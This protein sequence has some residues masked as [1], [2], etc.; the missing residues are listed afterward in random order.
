MK[1]RITVVF[2]LL[3][4][5]SLLTN[6][7]AAQESD[8][9]SANSEQF[10]QQISSIL[11]NTPSKTNQA[12]SQVILDRLYVRWTIGRFNKDEKDAVR[13][14]V[15][16]MRERKLKSYPYLYKYVYS[17]ML[18][19]ES[20]Q[21]PKSII[22]WHA[23]AEKMLGYKRAD[24]FVDFTDFTIELLEN[25]RLF[26][27][28]SLSWFHRQAR[29][30]F[31][32]DTNFLVK[33]E[34]LSLVCATKKDSSTIIETEGV[35][36]YDLQ[37]WTGKN[38][39][40]K[41]TRFGLENEDKIV[42]D[43]QDY[44]ID[45]SKSTYK[46]DSAVLHYERFFKNPVLGKFTEKIMSSPPSSR[47]SY[48]RFESYR[49]DFELMNIY[50]NINYYGGFYLNGLK[51]FG[52]GGEYNGAYITLNYNNEIFGKAN[53]EL[54]RLEEEKLEAQK[55]EVV[56]Y[57][58]KDSLYHPGLRLRYKTG[59]AEIQL[60]S[61][62]EGA[63]M[64]PFFD[65]YH[66]LDI[67][68]PAL[69]WKLDSTQMYFKRILGVHSEN[70]AAFVSSNYFSERDFYK[71][72]GI[73]EIN[74]MY[75]LQNYL[76][77][78]NDK[79]IQLNA[80]SAFMKKPTEQ[81]S[82][83]LINLSNNG[84]VV[85]NSREKTAIV[86]DR[87]YDFLDAK[88]GRSDYDIIRLESKVNR[89]ANAMLDLQ[90]LSLEVFGVP[91]VI[92][93]DSQD[94]YIYPYDNSISFKKNRDFSFDG[95]VHMGLFDF[96]S[97]SNTFVYDSFMINMN[98][99][100]SLAFKVYSTDSLSRIDSVIKVKNIVAE[101]N[102]KIYI[103]K[104]YNKSGLKKFEEYPIFI[105]EES[106]YVYFNEPF[107]QDSTLLADS[108]YFRIDPFQFDSIKT[109][110]T[111]GM[112]FSGTLVSAGIFPPIKQPLTVMPDYS[113]GFVHL[114]PDEGYPVYGGKGTFSDSIFLSNDGFSGSGKLD[115]LVSRT[116][117]DKYIFYP[118][119]LTSAAFEFKNMESPLEFDFPFAS[120]DTVNLKWLVDT[121][122]M[123]VENP[124]DSFSMY[125]NAKFDGNL[126]LNPENMNGLGAFHFEESEIQ[127]KYFTFNYSDLT[128]DSADFYLRKDVDTLVFQ[129]HGYFAKIDFEQQRAWFNHAYANTFV[130]FPYNKY[131][132]NLDEVEWLMDE[133][134]IE[135]FSDL[136]S[137]Y[138]GLDT[139]NDLDLIDYK[140]SGPEFI[141]IDNHPDSITRFFAGKATYNL[142]T[143][144]IDVENVK[145]IKS[146]DAAI[147]PNNEYVKILRDGGLL[148]L[149]NARIIADTLNKYHYIYEAEVDILNRHRYL[150]KGYI[151]YVD[152][153]LTRQPVYLLRIEIN[154]EGV[155]TG[156]G[157]MEPTEIFFLSPEYFFTG[158]I[159][160][161]ANN[162]FLNF[163]G[164]YRINEE[165][166][167]QEDKWVSFEKNLDP[168]NIYFNINENSLDLNQQKAR[169][170]LAYSA[171]LRS[172]YP[173]ILQSPVSSDDHVLIEAMGQIKYD[174]A[175]SSFRVSSGF[176][177]EKGVSDD[178]FVALNTTR[179]IL[180]GD[181]IFDLGLGFNKINITSAGKFRHLII[182]DSTYLNMAML[183]NFHFDD[184]AL[185]MMIDS[186]RLINS[187]VKNPGE[188]NFPVFLRK[189]LGSSKSTKLVTEISLYG[190][191]VK[192]PKAL[193]HTLIFSDLNM[194]W[195]GISNSFISQGP[196]GIGYIAGMPVNKYVNG[197]V[198]I[199]KGRSGSSINIY[200]E[201]TKN[202]W[203]FYTYQHGIMQVL[204]SDNEFNN[205]ISLLKPAKRVLNPESDT[206]YYEFVISTRRKV[207]DFLREMERIRKRF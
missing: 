13:S 184:G 188:G 173:L 17:L 63:D 192:V 71:I 76:K 137:N 135:L 48:P 156:M 100:D 70:V 23:Y 62:K 168:N 207:V 138:Q 124:I 11:L 98:Y 66:Q 120:A 5:W 195:D 37:L 55:A 189:V 165:C 110:S 109:F 12:K 58:E 74:P 68:S 77:I 186:L 33:Y 7:L 115:Y 161:R 103:D 90:S 151:D 132:S 190:Q 27:E 38:G 152:R 16:V 119:S 26:F 205:Y 92:L 204:S 50:P 43:L 201:L 54:F 105:S 155:T 150:A 21:T 22:G 102:G 46:A 198:Q 116:K 97:H 163:S 164:G 29:F 200:L 176:V 99:I 47:T 181:G 154:S 104:P 69:F 75:V 206:D 167:G 82:A 123:L 79:I 166:V 136:S 78:Y 171:D 73:D 20:H 178:N 203:Y 14:I 41:W 106:S 25:D 126:F 145:L 9:L 18:L 72:Q 2:V 182:P 160:F 42:V 96:Y 64:I 114:T 86:K 125:R 81:V 40:I 93:S 51:L 28:R 4:F 133:D 177:D 111:Q 134:K 179:C 80:L 147:F 117:S 32:L 65:S 197:Y 83:L 52:V 122:V 10:F 34:H 53:A 140:L 95:Q 87:F 129:S 158:Q 180:E 187:V 128:A 149:Q 143:F 15:E 175:S 146:A 67:Y 39:T 19:S 85:Y 30:K 174:T 170:G 162:E 130:E 31:E 89:Q 84:F 194:K 131:I 112:S 60:L 191:M 141:S 202:Q 3:V 44:R 153:N 6:K 35:F 144:T 121:N 193:E 24:K 118:D 88:S 183:M 8:S 57:F 1:V 199:K 127:S 61:D 159:G 148:T 56:F 36:N 94:V 107:I 59:N 139:L 157:D 49:D 196:I 172:F 113:L 91:E 142:N 101:L 45:I 108:F 185:D 169:F